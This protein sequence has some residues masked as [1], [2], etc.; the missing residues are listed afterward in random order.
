MVSQIPGWWLVAPVVWWIGKVGGSMALAPGGWWL[1]RLA[2]V[3]L[4]PWWSVVW[5][6]KYH[7]GRVSLANPIGLVVGGSGG[8]LVLGGWWLSH[9][10]YL[11]LRWVGG[12]VE[13]VVGG[14]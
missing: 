3:A 10:W 8:S 9:H 12:S 1:V 4:P 14:W 13:R 11:W 2:P 6:L 7:G 5:W